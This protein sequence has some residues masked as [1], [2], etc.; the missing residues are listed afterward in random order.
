MLNSIRV[1][2]FLS[3]FIINTEQK[4]SVDPIGAASNEAKRWQMDV[5]D[6]VDS[7]LVDE[8]ALLDNDFQQTEDISF[9]KIT[10]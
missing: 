5:D 3:D 9:G 1:T 8:D 4:S 6:M 2:Y 7:D 10:E